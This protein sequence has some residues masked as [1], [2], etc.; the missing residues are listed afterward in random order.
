M[1]AFGRPRFARPAL[2][3]LQ[4]A[5]RAGRV[6]LHGPHPEQIPEWLPDLLQRDGREVVTTSTLTSRELA[7]LA[8]DCLQR[9]GLDLAAHFIPALPQ[10]RPADA[11][12]AWDAG[13]LSAFRFARIVLPALA[14]RGRIVFV[15]ADA[16]EPL[17][18]TSLRIFARHAAAARNLGGIR[19]RACAQSRA[20][21]VLLQALEEAIAPRTR[22]SP[23]VAPLLALGGSLPDQRLSA[24]AW[25]ISEP[26]PFRHVD[27]GK[28][29]L[30][31][32][33]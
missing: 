9:G 24:K 31:T 19:L 2:T 13:F 18:A 16:A 12:A 27:P 30:R 23:L 4:P 17:P 20:G 10:V 22:P 8:Q 7:D 28:R 3:S 15:Q 11:R 1:P 25:K 14:A 33:V 6:L 26:D 32:T 29:N 5:Q 21:E